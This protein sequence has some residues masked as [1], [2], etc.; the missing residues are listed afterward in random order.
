MT[1]TGLSIVCLASILAIPC[2]PQAPA[3]DRPLIRQGEAAN[4]LA[5]LPQKIMFVKS[6]AEDPRVAIATTLITQVGLN[7]LTM[8][9]ASQMG[10]WNPYMNDAF[11]QFANIGKG[12]L[13]S[14][15]NDVKGFEYDTLPGLTAKTTLKADK[16]ELLI[17]VDMYRP[18]AD[19]SIEG[20]EPVLLHL[21]TRPQD[22]MRVMASRKV[23]IKE[24]KKG[25]FD[26][27]PTSERQESEVVERVVPID[28]ERQPGNIFRVTT[29]EPLEQ[30]EYALVL[31]G[32]SPK[33]A[34]TQNIALRPVSVPEAA[35][36]PD[37]P[38]MAGM[39]PGMAGM[40]GGGGT[41]PPSQ[42]PKRGGLFGMGKGSM[43]PQQAQA[44]NMAPGAPVAGFLAWDF[45][46]IQ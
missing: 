1:R 37:N 2:Y 42:Q 34:A 24:S 30:G 29:R 17:P 28:V 5:D 22:N 25:R 31:R 11:K 32:K 13:S 3:P 27:K 9:M 18:S 7:L 21:E 14:H 43:P 38:M 40:M 15:G 19:F 46:V 26:L 12:L 20:L 4:P 39:M 6:D 36:A 35:P 44:P 41:T 45:R 10:A 16:V 23:L 8:G 33:G